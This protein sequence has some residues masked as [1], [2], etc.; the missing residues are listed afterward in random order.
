MNNVVAIK[1]I[2]VSSNEYTTQLW[3]GISFQLFM[4]FMKFTS[5][6][7]IGETSVRKKR[8]ERGENFI[9]RPRS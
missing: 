3:L 7:T 9:K 5:Y 6:K 4:K 2:C 1:E 8:V